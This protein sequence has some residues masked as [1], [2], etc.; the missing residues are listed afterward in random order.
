MSENESYD[1]LLSNLYTDEDRERK[2]REE[3]KNFYYKRFLNKLPENLIEKVKSSFYARVFERENCVAIQNLTER[4]N[5]DVFM[6]SV[7]DL[8]TGEHKFNVYPP[9]GYSTLYPYEVTDKKIMGVVF[10]PIKDETTD[11]YAIEFAID[12]NNGALTEVRRRLYIFERNE[13]GEYSK[14]NNLPVTNFQIHKKENKV[15]WKYNDTTITVRSKHK[16][17]KAIYAPF[18]NMVFIMVDKDFKEIVSHYEVIMY[19]ANGDYIEEVSLPKGYM[20]H[21]VPTTH[22]IENQ[23]VYSLLTTNSNIEE[24]YFLRYMIVPDNLDYVFVSLERL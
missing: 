19:N 14:S 11:R 4:N 12:K 24:Y 16:I 5:K 22:I 10:A 1:S 20:I 13:N 7:Y 17:K 6:L 2:E 23:P 21:Y 15:V 18:E 9:M 3:R 8:K